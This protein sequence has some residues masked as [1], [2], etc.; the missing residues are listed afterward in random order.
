MKVFLNVKIYYYR[1]KKKDFNFWE[2]YPNSFPE[3]QSTFLFSLFSF[4][5]SLK[6]PKIE[7]GFFHRNVIEVLHDEGIRSLSSVG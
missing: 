1:S 6:P 2:S 7:V 3:L 5:F 4:L